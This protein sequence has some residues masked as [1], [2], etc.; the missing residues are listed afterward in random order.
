MSI[1]CEWPIRCHAKSKRDFWWRISP[2]S[3]VEAWSSGQEQN[4][5]IQ[6]S[7]LQNSTSLFYYACLTEIW[8]VLQ[9]A[10]HVCF[11]RLTTGSI[12]S[13]N[14]LLN[15][16]KWQVVLTG[17]ENA[18]K[19]PWETFF[20]SF[21]SLQELCQYHSGWQMSLPLYSKKMEFI[22]FLIQWQLALVILTASFS[23]I[24]PSK[25]FQWMLNEY[26]CFGKMPT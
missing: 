24:G 11:L 17:D 8:T 14:R 9:T 5:Q 3:F 4:M 20:A 16:L 13:R 26:S 10:A 7:L 18:W 22:L 23:C 15:K 25:N 12:C 6:S 19:R 2:G 1:Q 21:P